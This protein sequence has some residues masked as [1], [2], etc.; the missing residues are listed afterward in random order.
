MIAVTHAAR[1][2]VKLDKGAIPRLR[3]ECDVLWRSSSERLSK[4]ARLR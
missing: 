4:D 2:G 1:A 3:I